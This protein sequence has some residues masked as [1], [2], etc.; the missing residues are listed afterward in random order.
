MFEGVVGVFDGNQDKRQKSD[1]VLVARLYQQVGQLNADRLLVE[2]IVSEHWLAAILPPWLGQQAYRHPV[3][4]RTHRTCQTVTD[5]FEETW[6]EIVQWLETRPE[7]TARSVLEKL[8]GG[9]LGGTPKT[10]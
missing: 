2:Q 6:G 5:P 10:S 7:L 8:Q 3:K 4:P 9:I 1:D